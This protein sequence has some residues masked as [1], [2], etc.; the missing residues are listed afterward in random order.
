MRKA[1]LYVPKG[2]YL[3]S[4]YYFL[5]GYGYHVGPYTTRK[6]ASEEYRDYVMIRDVEVDL[7][8]RIS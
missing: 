5:D 2:Y 1:I 3:E 8:R 7:G 4:G 6:Q